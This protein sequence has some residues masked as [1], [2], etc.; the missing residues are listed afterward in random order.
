MTI[1]NKYYDFTFSELLIEKGANVNA[2][3]KDGCTA[4]MFIAEKK[5]AHTVRNWVESGKMRNATDEKEQTAMKQALETKCFNIAKKRVESGAKINTC[6]KYGVNAYA[7]AKYG[8]NK[9]IINFLKDQGADRSVWEA[10]VRNVRSLN[11]KN[12]PD[13]LTLTL[14]SPSMAAGVLKAGPTDI[15]PRELLRKMERRKHK[16]Q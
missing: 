9:D 14:Y 13:I 16:N 4:L 2:T 10:H 6:D 7:L 12:I 3:D 5:C 15:H 8:E 1:R 11:F